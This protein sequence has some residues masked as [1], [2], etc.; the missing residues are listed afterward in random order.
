MMRR[1]GAKR[2]S[3]MAG[4]LSTV[5]AADRKDY[6]GPTIVTSGVVLQ[7]SHDMTEFTIDEYDCMVSMLPHTYI[8]CRLYTNIYTFKNH[9]PQSME[10][11]I[12]R[13]AIEQN[14]CVLYVCTLYIIQ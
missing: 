3:G 2:E 4:V 9:I 12:V 13:Q 5:R 8:C 1:E 6:T 10:N 7:S 14:S 11:V